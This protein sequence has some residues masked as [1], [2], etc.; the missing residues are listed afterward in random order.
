MSRTK[1]MVAGSFPSPNAGYY[2]QRVQDELSLKFQPYDRLYDFKNPIRNVPRGMAKFAQTMYKF[3]KGQYL[4]R[5][6]FHLKQ[7]VKS[8]L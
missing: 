1:E 6:G 8:F 7:D 2:L 4:A 3:R 5:K